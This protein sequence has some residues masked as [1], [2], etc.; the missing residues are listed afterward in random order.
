MIF[1]TRY[2]QNELKGGPLC[3]PNPQTYSLC[4]F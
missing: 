1:Q 2:Q 3:S 4:V